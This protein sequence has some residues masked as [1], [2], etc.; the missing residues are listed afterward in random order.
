MV[1]P[2][3]ARLAAAMSELCTQTSDTL[4]TVAPQQTVA[5]DAFMNAIRILYSM[6]PDLPRDAYDRLIDSP[7][8]FLMTA[9]E[10]TLAKIWDAVQARQPVRYKQA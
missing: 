6:E 4:P 8:E 7:C 10:P 1:Y 2:N 9:D 3:P 5:R